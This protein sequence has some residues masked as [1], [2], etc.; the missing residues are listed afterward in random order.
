M[1][2]PQ[3]GAPGEL[4]TDCHQPGAIFY[5]HMTLTYYCEACAARHNAAWHSAAMAAF[6]H[7]LCVKGV[8][9]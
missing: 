2:Q 7:A 3:V 5:N 6:G 8:F 1:S 4:C 9:L